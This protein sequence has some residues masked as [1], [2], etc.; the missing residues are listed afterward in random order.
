MAYAKKEMPASG[1]S[2]KSSP[3]GLMDSQLYNTFLEVVE[4]YRTP[5]GPLSFKD[6]DGGSNN[7]RSQALKNT[8][9]S[10]HQQRVTSVR[11]TFYTYE[12]VNKAS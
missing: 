6:F 1:R 8:S 7:I 10:L 5:W 3:L 4:C 12:R 9:V 2:L 11:K